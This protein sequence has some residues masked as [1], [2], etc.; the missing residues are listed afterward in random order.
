MRY[1]ARAAAERSL[2]YAH[3]I[4][5]IIRSFHSIASLINNISIIPMH[6]HPRLHSYPN[7][8]TIIIACVVGVLFCGFAAYDSF[9]PHTDVPPPVPGSS[10][11]VRAS[12][13]IFLRH[14]T[15]P[16][17]EAIAI[18]NSGHAEW[19]QY[20]LSTPMTPE[21]TITLTSDEMATLKVFQHTWCMAP[22]TYA[23]APEESFYNLGVQCH[24]VSYLTQSRIPLNA[25][26]SL[27]LNG[28]GSRS[29]KARGMPRPRTSCKI[30]KT[31][32]HQEQCLG[33]PIHAHMSAS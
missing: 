11:N 7:R 12:D 30:Q 23:I 22:P 1:L 27:L 24:S 2:G 17:Y 26:A 9:G 33:D 14:T 15:D 31:R 10:I 4:P 25:L 8:R 28:R 3:A 5:L 18:Y 19:Y 16:P 32:D 21:A 6:H 13:F 29:L 20:P